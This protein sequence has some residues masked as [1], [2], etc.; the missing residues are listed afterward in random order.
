MALSTGQKIGIGAAAAVGLFWLV[1]R[2]SKTK[3]HERDFYFPGDQI[4]VWQ[5]VGFAMR[6]PAGQWMSLSDE[7]QITGQTQFGNT[8]T[9]NVIAIAAPHD[10]VVNAIFMRADDSRVQEKFIV[11][12]RKPI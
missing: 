1:S 3:A 5:G 4:V 7:L 10:Y 9:V 8:T 11:T 6:M 2:G 12:A